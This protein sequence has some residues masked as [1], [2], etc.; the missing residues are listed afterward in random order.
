MSLRAI[1]HHMPRKRAWSIGHGAWSEESESR[2]E[3][4]GFSGQVSHSLSVFPDTRNLTPDT[5]NYGA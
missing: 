1:A 5:L 4:S 2:I 3:V